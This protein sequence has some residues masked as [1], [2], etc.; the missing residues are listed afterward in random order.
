MLGRNCTANVDMGHSV[1]GEDF[2]LNPKVMSTIQSINSAA[3]VIKS[4]VPVD[5]STLPNRSY[6]P[7]A[8][9]VP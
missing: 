6:G 3:R 8:D 1:D 2:H 5:P 7:P 4:V 9:I